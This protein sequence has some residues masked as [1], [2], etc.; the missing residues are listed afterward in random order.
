[1]FSPKNRATS[2]I[3][4]MLL[5]VAGGLLIFLSS[6]LPSAEA[7]NGDLPFA[8]LTQRVTSDGAPLLGNPSA[9]VTVVVFTDFACPHCARYAATI[10]EFIQTRV[11]SG[12][13]RLELRILNGIDPENS[14]MAA[15][16]ASCASEQSQFWFFQNALFAL[17]PQ[18]GRT[19]FT[20]NR[21]VSTATHL[22]IDETDF[23]LCL[24][25][26]A[27]VQNAFQ[28]NIDLALAL[29]VQ[30]L[31][32]VL[33]RKGNNPPEWIAG[34]GGPLRGPVSFATLTQAIDQAL[35]G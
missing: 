29:D 35:E 20:E 1:M 22:G 21:L 18:Y 31:P 16:A 27:R 32:A 11:Q 23:Q 33:I 7:A 3:T 17:Q 5:V 6:R 8:T 14:P 19:A 13:A 30:T 28:R 4:I 12:D 26:R 24:A 2:L 10:N 34:S 15:N 9:P 25:R